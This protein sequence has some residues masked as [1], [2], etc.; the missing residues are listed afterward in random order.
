M[1]RCKRIVLVALILV[2]CV[3][4]DPVTKEAARTYLAS[5]PALS[6]WG[7]LFRLEYA[8][9]TGAFLDASPFGRLISI[10]DGSPVTSH[11]ALPC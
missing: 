8:E 2:G 6:Y 4:C 10:D 1:P 7:N 5:T 11:L 3:G 9:N